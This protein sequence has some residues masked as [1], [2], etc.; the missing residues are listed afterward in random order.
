[1]K[2][3]AIIMLLLFSCIKEDKYCGTIIEKYR[4]PAGYKIHSKPHVV[5]YSDSLKRNV[6]VTVTDN[7]YVNSY[8]G[9]RI[10]FQL[11]EYQIQ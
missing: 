1:M 2:K 10:C 8:V 11:S 4:S 7:T 9:K 5:F 6:D 3:Y